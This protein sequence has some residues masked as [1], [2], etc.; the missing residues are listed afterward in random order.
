MCIKELKQFLEK[1]MAA[2]AQERP[3]T[4]SKS[5]LA[6][7]YSNS[8]HVIHT[9]FSEFIRLAELKLNLVLTST[10]NTAHAATQHSIISDYLSEQSF[11]TKRHSKNVLMRYLSKGA[12]ANFDEW[13]LPL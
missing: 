8:E 4:D 5:S 12:D 13:A 7:K 9:L 2:A 11:T 1:E 3:R 10:S 6:S